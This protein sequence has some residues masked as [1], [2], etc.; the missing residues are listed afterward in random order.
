M[1]HRRQSSLYE[2]IHS[3]F[4]NIHLI[5]VLTYIQVVSGDTCALIPQKA[6]ISSY[7]LTRLNPN[8]DCGVLF[9]GQSLCIKDSTY[10]CQPVYLV[11]NGDSCSGIAEANHIT[12]NQLIANNPNVGATCNTL[13]P[14]QMLCIAAPT[15]PASWFIDRCH[16]ATGCTSTSTVKSGDNCDLIASSNHISNYQLSFLNPEMSCPTLQIG[17]VLCLVSNT[18]NCQPVYTVK[19]GDGCISIADANQITLA[20][21]FS[22][23]PD[24]GGVCNIY[25]GQS[26]CVA[27]PTPTTTDPPTPTSTECTRKTTVQKGDNCDTISERAGIS[28]YWLGLLNPAINAN[29][30]NLVG[31]TALCIDSAI[32]TCGAVYA[33][34]GTEGACIGIAST[35]R[36]PFETLLNLN[37]NVNAQ[38]TN[39]YVGEVLCTAKKVPG[40]PS[41]ACSRR[42][43]LV[44]GDTCTIAAS[45]SSLTNAQLL[46]LNPRLSCGAMI[47]DTQICAFSPATSICPRL[48]Q[49]NL[50]DSCFSLAQ[51]VSMSLEEWQS[52]NPG[53][54]CNPL[55]LNYLVCSAHGNATLPEQPSGSN[56]TALPLCGAYDKAKFCCTKFSVSADLFSSPLCQRANGCQ[57]NCIG[58]PGVVKPTASATPT[59]TITPTNYPTPPP[60]PNQCGNCTAS[61]CC[62]ALGVCEIA[63][64]SW[65]C[66]SANG[67]TKNCDRGLPSGWVDLPQ[68]PLFNYTFPAGN[69]SNFGGNPCGVCNSTTAAI[70]SPSGKY[71]CAQTVQ[72]LP[73]AFEDC[74][75]TN[76]CLFNCFDTFTDDP[77]ECERTG[78]CAYTTTRIPQP[79]KSGSPFGLALGS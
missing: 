25:P 46:T 52:I 63:L 17:Q 38:C 61:Q 26:L 3:R 62:T 45:K 78:K 19:P 51:N 39:I 20:Q 41:T 48:I 34:K 27:P 74:R 31:G 36:I 77:D 11:K 50:G 28:R 72:C 8:L 14:G 66:Q 75:I 73:E 55:A 65:Y 67:C 7:Q 4:Y 54:N 1:G 59:F 13:Q 10:D 32:N 16:L 70:V 49:T 24:L 58:D 18:Y 22:D 71:C 40:T 33:V 35:L 12:T 6:S 68:G 5:I 57:A 43:T 47:P 76:G 64:S 15:N 53:L 56:P 23:N 42:Y 30:S 79:W 29:C 44:S 2:D 37:P 60:E 9:I 69:Y 21:L